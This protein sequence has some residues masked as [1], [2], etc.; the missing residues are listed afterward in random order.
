MSNNWRNT[1]NR[2][3]TLSTMALAIIFLSPDAAVA[4]TAKDLVGTWMNVS[5]VNIRQDGS[6]VDVF[7]P[8]GTGMAIFDSNVEPARSK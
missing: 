8:K 7:G 1:M 5:N 2:L 4:Q 3:I 6:R